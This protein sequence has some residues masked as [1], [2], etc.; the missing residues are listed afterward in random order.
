MPSWIPKIIYGTGPT[1]LTFP[2]VPCGDPLGEVM[3]PDVVLQESNVG[4]RQNQYNHTK[5]YYSLDF[6]FLSSTN[7]ADL[8]TFFDWAKQNGTFSYYP[9][10][11][12]GTYKTLYLILPQ[13]ITWDRM[14]ADGAGDFVY[15]TKFNVYEVYV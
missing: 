10:N 12:L 5:R 3:S 2:N 11:E 8:Q 15:H 4:V 14:F 6:T 1:T 9:S 7:K 13:D